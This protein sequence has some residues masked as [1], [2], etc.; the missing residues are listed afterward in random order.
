M[1]D[2][3]FVTQ[4]PSFYKVNL[5]NEIS[6]KCR[7]KVIFLGSSSVERTKDFTSSEYRFDYEFLRC[8]DFETRQVFKSLLKLRKAL[9]RIDYKLVLFSGWNLPEF[10]YV[11]F[12]NLKSKNV[13]VLESSIRESTLRGMK[14][15]LKKVFISR[16]GTVM[17]SGQLHIAL[18]KD[19]GF[20]GKIS[21]T[22]GVGIINKPSRDIS[23]HHFQGKFLYLGRLSPEKNLESIMNTFNRFTQFTLTIVGNGPQ[24]EML[25]TI[26]GPNIKFVPHVQNQ[27]IAKVF[28][29]Q[30]V[31]ILGSMSEPWGLVVE[32]ALYY[33]IPVLVSNYCGSSELVENGKNGF[34]FNPDKDDDLRDSLLRFNEDNYQEM[35]TFIKSSFLDLKDEM[36]VASYVGLTL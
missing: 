22:K 34:V 3:V 16:V 33:G 18:L 23:Q 5:Y 6:S 24:Y 27:D 1:Y 28:A 9:S 26:A 35:L 10:W 19:L 12:S 13:L 17:A 32:E 8:N 4:L 21:I 11:L 2:L 30:D 15:L 25:T 7:I 14:G 31:L 20:S 29:D 36:Q